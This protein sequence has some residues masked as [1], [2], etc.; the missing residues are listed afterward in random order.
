MRSIRITWPA[1]LANADF[2]VQ[3]RRENRSWAG[4]TS[5]YAGPE[6]LLLDLTGDSVATR[7]YRSLAG[8]LPPALPC[9]PQPGSHHGDTQC[10]PEHLLA[11]ES[12]GATES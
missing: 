9:Q 2:D 10:C 3:F 4:E 1:Q 7:D 12:L 8:R 6:E 11:T 5:Q